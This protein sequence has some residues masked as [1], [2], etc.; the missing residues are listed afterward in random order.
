[1]YVR[2]PQHSITGGGGGGNTPPPPPLCQ[3]RRLCIEA[4]NKNTQTTIY[5]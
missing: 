1:M 5:F 3:D 4:R 2:G